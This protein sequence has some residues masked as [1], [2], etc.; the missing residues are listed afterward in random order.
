MSRWAAQGSTIQQVGSPAYG[1]LWSVG[2][3]AQQPD[4]C[5]RGYRCGGLKRRIIELLG[6]AML[7]LGRKL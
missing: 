2:G 1:R 5:G 6:V 3:V 7:V 4:G